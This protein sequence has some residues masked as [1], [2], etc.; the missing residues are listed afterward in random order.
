M[1]ARLAPSPR[2]L[3]REREQAAR[4]EGEHAIN[5]AAEEQNNSPTPHTGSPLP[6]AGEG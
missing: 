5:S 3:K 6:L 4:A 2:P 1:P